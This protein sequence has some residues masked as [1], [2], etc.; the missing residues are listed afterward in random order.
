MTTVSAAIYENGVV[1]PAVK[2]LRPPREVVVVFVDSPSNALLAPLQP[3]IS[4]ELKEAFRKT[5]GILP[6][7]FPDGVTFENAIRKETEN[8]LR[9]LDW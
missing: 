6:K 3:A 1:I 8:R 5:R 9:Q 2:P 4:S 7:D